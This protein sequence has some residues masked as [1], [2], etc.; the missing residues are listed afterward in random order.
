MADSL[1]LI[2]QVCPAP[3]DNAGKLTEMA[4]GLRGELLDLDVQWID[5]PGE[6]VPVGAKASADTAGLFLMR[7]DPK[8]LRGVFDKVTDWAAGSDRTVE[9]RAGGH[10]L[11]RVHPTS[12]QQE[13]VIDESPVPGIEVSRVRPEGETEAVIDVSPSDVPDRDSPLEPGKVLVPLRT[14]ESLLVMRERR[15]LSRRDWLA[16]V[17][18]EQES[19]RTA[20]FAGISSLL[21]VGFVVLLT[22]AILAIARLFQGISVSTSYPV[23]RIYQG[24]VRYFDHITPPPGSP[25]M[26]LVYTVYLAVLP[27]LFAVVFM[28]LKVRSIKLIV[29]ALACIIFMGAPFVIAVTSIRTDSINCGSW[30]YPEPSSGS[31]CYNTLTSAFRIA[32]L[33]GIV[34]LVVPIMYLIRGRDRHKNGLLTALIAG[35]SVVMSVFSFIGDR[36]PR[37]AADGRDVATDHKG[38]AD[39]DK[40]LLPHEQQVITVRQHPAVLIGPSVLALDGLLVAGVLTVTVLHGN[41]RLVT[42]VWI[43]WLALFA[44]MIWKAIDWA[45]TFFVITSHR[46]LLTSGVLFRRVAMVPLAKVTDMTFHRPFLGRLLGFGDFILESAGQDQALSRIE[47]LPYPEQLYLEVCA[48]LFPSRDPSDD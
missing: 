5:R 6:A 36:A 26:L 47:H 25:H 18:L 44:R 33:V 43:V 9:I 35:A 4:R 30:I 39:V 38:P 3:G 11:K 20:A 37:Q 41:G 22:I 17:V 19:R 24:I 40:Y 42:V 21:G 16:G 14:S 12:Q 15:E 46:M 2:L 28:H 31:E 10:S 34:G 23:H 8:A 13:K 45:I 29:A 27:V 7:L 32:F 1:E 48:L